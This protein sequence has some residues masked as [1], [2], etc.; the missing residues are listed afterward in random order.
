[1][2]S[3]PPPCTQLQPAS[4]ASRQ[5]APISVKAS[6]QGSLHPIL[7]A[8]LITIAILPGAPPARTG[9]SGETLHR[10]WVGWGASQTQ[11]AVGNPCTR[12]GPEE[13]AAVGKPWRGLRR[14]EIMYDQRNRPQWGN[15][16]WGWCGLGRT[17]TMNDQRNRPQWGN[18]GWG[19]GG[20]GRTDIMNDQRNRQQWGYPGAG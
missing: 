4:S 6:E 11:G 5:V 8:N 12:L 16:G 2:V 14:T 13:Q 19:W 9:R 7:R 15:P 10:A 18:P 3:V 20:L 17:D 1:M